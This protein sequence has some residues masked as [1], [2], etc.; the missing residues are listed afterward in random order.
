MN[1]SVRRA[2]ASCGSDQCVDLG[3]ADEVVF[4]E[5]ADGVGAVAHQTTAVADFQIRVMVFLL[6]TQADALTKDMV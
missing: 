5:T 6:D 3:G 2:M 1:V 4:G